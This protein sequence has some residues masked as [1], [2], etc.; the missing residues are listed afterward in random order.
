MTAP[1]PVPRPPVRQPIRLATIR[2]TSSITQESI[3]RKQATG[4]EE[5]LV[6]R[7]NSRGLAAPNTIVGFS[8]LDQEGRGG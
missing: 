6:N 7:V 1:G 3:R 5:P 8:T 4:S 2:E